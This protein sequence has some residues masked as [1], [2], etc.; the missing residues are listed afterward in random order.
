MKAS[1]GSLLLTLLASSCSKDGDS[2]ISRPNCSLGQVACG[3]QC[4]DVT[5]DPTNC[6]GCGIP[7]PTEDLPGQTDSTC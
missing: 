1:I 6:G 2:G 4:I 7:C 3:Q 5:A